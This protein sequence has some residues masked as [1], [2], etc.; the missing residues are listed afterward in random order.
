MFLAAN[1]SPSVQDQTAEMYLHQVFLDFNTAMLL[2]LEP[3]YPYSTYST[4]EAW[5]F[6]LN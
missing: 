1:E 3:K 2:V 5:H 6:C 4:F